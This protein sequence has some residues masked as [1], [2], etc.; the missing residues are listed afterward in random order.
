MGAKIMKIKELDYSKGEGPRLYTTSNTRRQVPWGWP[1]DTTW[2]GWNR[3]RMALLANESK[4]LSLL[5]GGTVPDDA[6]I[7]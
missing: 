6:D 1:M 5:R 3:Y 4:W 2:I 7:P